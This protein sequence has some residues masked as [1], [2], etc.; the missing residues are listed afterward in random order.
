MWL[1]L[2]RIR[3]ILK[4][5]VDAEELLAEIDDDFGDDGDEEDDAD[6]QADEVDV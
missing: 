5:G 6:D 4:F 3:E 2:A 1:I